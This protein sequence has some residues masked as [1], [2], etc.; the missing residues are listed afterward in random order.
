MEE[1]DEMEGATELSD[2]Q[3]RQDTTLSTQKEES[4]T[5]EQQLET[6]KVEG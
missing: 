1:T 6:G 4:A 3:G 2:S 5:D